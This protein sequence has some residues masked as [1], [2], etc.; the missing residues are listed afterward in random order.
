[1]IHKET[2]YRKDKNSRHTRRGN[3]INTWRQGN[4]K[5]HKW[6]GKENNDTREN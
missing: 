3:L 1:M 4:I 2:I 6:R 5:E